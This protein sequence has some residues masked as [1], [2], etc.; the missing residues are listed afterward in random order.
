VLISSRDAADYGR[1]ISASG[2]RG[3]LSKAD[4]SVQA[5]EAMLEETP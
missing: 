5:L 3:F 2:A 4:L 1:R